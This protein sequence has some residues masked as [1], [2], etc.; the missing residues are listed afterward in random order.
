MGTEPIARPVPDTGRRLNL[1]SN[2]SS[3]RRPSD[4]TTC[5]VVGAGGHGRELA[6]IIRDGETAGE[7]FRLLGL[8]DDG[9]VDRMALARAGFRFLGSSETVTQRDVLA[10]LGLGYPDVRRRVAQRIGE[11][12][13]WGEPLVHPSA[14]IGSGSELG[15]GSVL[16]QGA[17]VT[18]N[19]TIGMHS[20]IGVSSTVSHDC[21][22]GDFVT[23]CPGATITGSVQIGDD[24]F[25]GA[26]ATILP[27]VTVGTGAV[28]GAGATVTKDVAEIITVVGVPARTL[29]DG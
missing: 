9:D 13:Q 20:H 10:Y 4:I 18:T 27:G 5:V 15:L 17:V 1:S 12:A 8:V 28:I 29:H 6:D 2:D 7:P 24:V 11:D 22:L 19:V 21:Q 3:K 26:G 23:V 16:A 14:Q 25:V